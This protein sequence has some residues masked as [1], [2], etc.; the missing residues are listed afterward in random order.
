[1]GEG[2]EVVKI[3]Y[4]RGFIRIK[5]YSLFFLTWHSFKSPQIDNFQLHLPVF[6]KSTEFTAL[7]DLTAC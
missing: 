2:W 4:Y 5:Y 7:V 3:N 1:M 6:Q